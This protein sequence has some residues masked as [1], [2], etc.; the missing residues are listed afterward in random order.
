MMRCASFA[1]TGALL[2]GAEA[3]AQ[4]AVVRSHRGDGRAAARAAVW[5]QVLASRCPGAA[6]P[7]LH[8]IELLGLPHRQLEIVAR[9]AEGRSNRDIAGE[10]VRSLR[11][12]ENHLSRAYRHLEVDGRKGLTPL[13]G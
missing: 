7:A 2:L 4:A 5:A 10:L 3:F 8:G 13:F 11:T 1:A 9:A 12:V 6:T